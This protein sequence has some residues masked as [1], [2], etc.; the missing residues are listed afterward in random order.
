MK[1]AYGYCR[2]STGRQDLTFDVQREKIE[3]YYKDRLAKDGYAWGG[4]FEDKATSGGKPFTEREQGRNLWVVAQPGDAIIWYKMDRAFRSVRDGA[5]TLDL[6]KQKRI[7]VHSIDIGLDTSSALGDFVCKLLML[8]GELERSWIS[9]RT[10]DAF[11]AK[12]AKGLP[13]NDAVPAGW[14][15]Y[16]KKKSRHLVEDLEERDLLDE[17]YAK[18]LNGESIEKIARQ[19][20]AKH[21]VRYNG[22]S[23][24]LDFLFY[25]LHARALGYPQWYGRSRHKAYLKWLQSQGVNLRKHGN[26]A[27]R[28]NDLSTVGLPPHLVTC[29]AETG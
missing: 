8:L 6:L 25:A 11:E 7:A 1:T 13:I 28:L 9:S 26:V 20:R 18:W 21:Q 22:Q 4:F 3:T 10:K 19:I 12:R 16:G 2:A 23:I 15:A 17:V 24:H 5:N 14:K 29:L 27:K